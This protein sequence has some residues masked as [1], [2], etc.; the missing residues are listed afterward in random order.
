MGDVISAGSNQEEFWLQMQYPSPPKMLF[1]RYDE[2]E[3]QVGPR[4]MLPV[5]PIWIR[6]ALGI[7][8]IDPTHQTTMSPPR[9]TDGFVELT[10][11]IPSGRRMYSRTLVVDPMSVTIHE[12]ILRDAATKRMV[13]HA[14][15]SEHSHYAAV[16][17]SL[18]H[19]VDVQLSPDV[20]PV[21]AFTVE[22]WNFAINDGEPADPSVFVKPDASGMQA[23]DLVRV[24][25]A[26]QPAVPTNPAYTPA[27]ANARLPGDSWR[28]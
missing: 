14:K 10:T 20:G 19:R 25:A 21:L 9:P 17:V 11:L 8:E 7:V 2:F 24:N 12:T 23:W 6:E 5:S 22:I 15:Q 16:G 3:N 4:N 18:P 28:R 27:A 13:A 1:A 26:E